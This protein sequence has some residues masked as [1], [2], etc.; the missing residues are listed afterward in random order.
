MQHGIPVNASTIDR[1]AVIIYSREKQNDTIEKFST[2]VA[3]ID[4]FETGK[5]RDAVGTRWCVYCP[6]SC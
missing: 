1:L 2:K 4:L 3:L 6:G 5:A